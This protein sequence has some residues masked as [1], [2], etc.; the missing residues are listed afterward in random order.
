MI[1]LCS[2]LQ[3]PRWRVDEEEVQE[4][5]TTA[6]QPPKIRRKNNTQSLDDKNWP[7]DTHLFNIKGKHIPLLQQDPRIQAVLRVAIE[8]LMGDLLFENAFPDNGERVRFSRDAVIRAGK[9]LHHD[10]MVDRLKNDIG[11]LERVAK[12]VSCSCVYGIVLH[13]RKTE[14]ASFGL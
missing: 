9:S 11:Y 14:S 7:S 6:S 10:N 2:I 8:E 13:R 1:S 3:F 4:G 5:P 12:V